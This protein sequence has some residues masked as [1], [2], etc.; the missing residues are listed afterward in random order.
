MTNEKQSRSFR[1][2]S[3]TIGLGW[4]WLCKDDGDLPYPIFADV[5]NRRTTFLVGVPS[6]VVIVSL[7]QR[8]QAVSNTSALGAG[9]RL[10]PYS[11]V[12]ALASAA[13]NVLCSKKA[14]PLILFLVFGSI[15][16][17]VG[18]ALLA[19]LPTTGGFPAAGYGYEVLA[20]AGVG[21]TFRILILATPFVIEARDLGKVILAVPLPLD[22]ESQVLFTF[23]RQPWPLAS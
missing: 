9:I 7:P 14:I 8:F 22:V 17:V 20:G 21:I 1:G 23:P 15:V 12:A 11:L 2:A 5:N 6:N 3:F 4:R 19:T 10:I 13:A 16:H 18:L